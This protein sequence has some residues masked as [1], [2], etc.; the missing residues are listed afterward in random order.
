[1]KF[2]AALLLACLPEV[3]LA[4]C[5]EHTLADPSRVRLAGDAVLIVTHPSSTYD[6]RVAAKRGTDDAVRFAKD[7]RIPVVYLQDD[8]PLRYYYVDDC[9][10][11]YWVFSKGGEV[12]FDLPV[13]HVYL[14][15]GHL[16]LCLG[17]TLNDVL[18]IWSRKPPRSLTVT[19]LMDGIYSNGKSVEESDPYY[20]DF[21]RFMRVVTYGRPA[22]EHWPKLTL[23]ETM[24]VIN[25]EE[26]EL[27]YLKKILPRW[28]RTM[29]AEYRI[30][31]QL[32]DSVVKVLRPGPGWNP[33]TLRFHFVDSASAVAR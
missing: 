3:A 6:A 4:V 11:D 29:P 7:N 28:D 18:L 8:S 31:L 1:M 16:E 26:H 30:E 2:L 22:G 20:G 23:L 14:A 13:S 25:K 33:P 27:E 17:E 19:F 24:G 21:T 15:G 9:A 10:P 5:A 12:E 32:N